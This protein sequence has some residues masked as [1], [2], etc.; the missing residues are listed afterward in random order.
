MNKYINPILNAHDEVR[1]G[2]KSLINQIV[3]GDSLEELRKLPSE[4]VDCVVTSPPYNKGYYDKHKAHP[5]DTWAQRNIKYGDFADNLEPQDYIKQQKDILKELVRIIKPEGSIFYN[6]K[7]VRSNQRI[8]FPTYVF[9]FCVRQVLIWDRGSSPQVAPIIWYPTTEYIFW[10]TKTNI[11]PKFY[12]KGKFDKEIWRIIAKAEPD[13]P[14]PFPEELVV[15]CLMSTTD[16]GDLV[17]DPY[18]G[19][20]TTARVAKNLGRNFIGIEKNPEYIKY[21]NRRLAQEVLF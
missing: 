9:D 4:S 7:S 5:T 20:G 14:A 2:N 15:Q 19:S 1:E 10:I 3:E 16:E 12:R 17:L 6:H 11:Q 8:I 13:H 21:A 18:M